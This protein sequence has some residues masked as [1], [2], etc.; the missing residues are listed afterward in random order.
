MLG[1]LTH[2]EG[3]PVSEQQPRAER[4]L[5]GVLYWLPR[6]TVTEGRSME[7]VT[8]LDQGVTRTCTVGDHR[9]QWECGGNP[10][11]TQPWTVKVST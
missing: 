2:E 9:V 10:P 5:D 8:R 6:S 1:T 11:R 4:V 7:V 3:D